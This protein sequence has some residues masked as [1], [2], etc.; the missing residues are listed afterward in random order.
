MLGGD[1]MSAIRHFRRIDIFDD[2]NIQF[3]HDHYWLWGL[4]T[5]H[6]KCLLG[7]HKWVDCGRHGAYCDICPMEKNPDGNTQLTD[8][9]KT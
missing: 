7:F 8:L 6:L 4:R 3:W 1:K 9:G 2:E 5:L